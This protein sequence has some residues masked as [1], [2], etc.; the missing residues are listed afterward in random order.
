MNVF[1]LLS[2]SHP[3]C[4]TEEST[5]S[6]ATITVILIFS[7]IW[8]A[9]CVILTRKACARCLWTKV[10]RLKKKKNYESIHLLCS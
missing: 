5:I 9:S 2:I 3:T 1:G 7:I 8:N 4:F 6:R 10:L